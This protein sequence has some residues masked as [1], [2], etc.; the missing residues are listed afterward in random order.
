MPCKKEKYYLESYGLASVEQ[1]EQ[2]QK[3]I[4]F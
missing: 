4:V 2:E 3:A 1:I